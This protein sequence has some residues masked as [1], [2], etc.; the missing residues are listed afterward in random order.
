VARYGLP[1][2]QGAVVTALHRG[3]PAM[4]AGLE[5]GDIIVRLNDQPVRSEE[6]LQAIEKQLKIGQRVSVEVVR[7]EERYRGTIVVGEAP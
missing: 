1:D 6:D 4:T 3:S 7:Y 5:A 2:V